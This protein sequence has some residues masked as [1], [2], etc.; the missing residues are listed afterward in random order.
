MAGAFLLLASLPTLAQNYPAAEVSGGF[1]YLHAQG[2]S[3][4]YG[5]DASIAVNLNRWFGIDSEFS[6]HYGPSFG[7]AV[8]VLLPAPLPPTV[9]NTD[10]NSNVYTFLFGPQVSYRRH[11]TLTPFAHVLAGFA[12]SGFSVTVSSPTFNFHTSG[13]SSAFAMAIGGGVDAR[14]TRSLDF[15]IIQVDYLPTRFSSSTQNNARITT[16]LVYRF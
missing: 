7:G 11:K 13:S 5:W 1:S 15:R 2:G 9:V 16:G 4:L 10:T 12:R 14:L 8:A 3:N 6:G